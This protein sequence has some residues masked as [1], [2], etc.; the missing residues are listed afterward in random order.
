MNA[1]DDTFDTISPEIRAFV[2]RLVGEMLPDLETLRQRYRAERDARLRE[3][4]NAQYIDVDADFSHYADDPYVDQP[5]VRDAVHE[6]VEVAVIGGGF[7]G[8]LAGAELR[9]RGFDDILFIDKAGDFG[10][11]WY[12]NRYPGVMCDTESYIYIPLLEDVG[13]VPGHKYSTGDEILQQMKRIARHF[14]LYDRT[15]FQTKVTEA[16]WNEDRGRWMIS[17]DRGDSIDAKYVVIANGVLERPKLPGIPGIDAFEGHTFHTSRWD[18]AYTGG[19]Q[20]GELTGLADKQVGIVGTGATAIQCIPHLGRWA[21]H[22]YVF[23]R[24]PAAV[25]RKNNPATDPAWVRSLEPGWQEL[26]CRNFNNISS[27]VVCDDLVDDGFSRI[28]F[29]MDVTAGWAARQLGRPLSE[30]EAEFVCETADAKVMEELRSGIDE[31]VEDALVAERLKPW[32]RRWCKRPLFHEDY[33]DTFNRSNVTLVDTAGRGI[34]RFTANAAI[35]DGRP[36]EVDCLIFASGFETGTSLAHRAGFEVYGTNGLSLTDH[37]SDGMLT[38]HGMMAN[39]FPNCFFN[40]FG[41]NAGSVNLSHMFHQNAIHI[42]AIL[43]ECK[44]RDARTVE[45]SVAAVGNYVSDAYIS[46]P[47]ATKFWAEC[48]PSYFNGEGSAPSATGFFA[49]VHGRGVNGFVDVLEQWRG[50][51]NFEGLEITS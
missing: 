6:T 13:Y 42:A 25:R 17:T 23:Q 51:G 37:W 14:N 44:Q 38:L 30:A 45:A 3:G 50:E 2:E 9:R 47:A 21:G 33:L 22:L 48:T 40:I 26:R 4:G 27:G 24:T 1:S 28:A 36:Y 41:Q 32:H 34:E 5:L 16:R 11:T 31:T 12:W 35:V 20:F 49:N 8:L 39:G 10:G 43:R 7:G 19:S 15:C 18:Y 46:N 29:L